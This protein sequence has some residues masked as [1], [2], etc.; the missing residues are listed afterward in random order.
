M[1]MFF[2]GERIFSKVFSVLEIFF[3]CFCLYFHSFSELCVAMK[4]KLNF[5]NFEP[6]FDRI[7]R[8]NKFCSGLVSFI[9]FESLFYS[10]S[11]VFFKS[12]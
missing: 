9:N 8:E 4:P 10:L 11:F 5:G 3:Q 12:G 6:S 1:K 2:S 7:L